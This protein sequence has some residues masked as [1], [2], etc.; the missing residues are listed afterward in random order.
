MPRLANS[1]ARAE[2]TPATAD[3]GDSRPASTAGASVVASFS[4]RIRLQ[5][6]AS[7]TTDCNHERTREWAVL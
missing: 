2:P 3:T 4:M 6:W 7:I 1:R 5:N